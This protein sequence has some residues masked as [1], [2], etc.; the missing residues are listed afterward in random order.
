MVEIQRVLR[1]SGAV[2]I[3]ENFGSGDEQ[4]KPPE[5]LLPYYEALVTSYGFSHQ[6]I[7]TDSHFDSVEEA[8]HLFRFFFGEQFADRVKA[9]KSPLVPACTGVWWRTYD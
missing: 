2:I 3:F 4:P 1:P 9:Q 6:Y 5:N 7:R 8:E